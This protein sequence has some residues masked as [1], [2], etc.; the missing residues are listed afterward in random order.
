MKKIASFLIAT[1]MTVTCSFTAKAF[2]R[3]SNIP[4][5]LNAEQVNDSSNWLEIATDRD[6][7]GNNYSLIIRIKAIKKDVSFE[8]KESYRTG[9]FSYVHSN[10]RSLV[11]YWYS[12]LN[13]QILKDNAV[14]SDA[15]KKFGEFGTSTAPFG[16]SE[17]S[18]LQPKAGEQDVAFL[19]SYQ[20][21]YNFVSNRCW[22]RG[23]SEQPGDQVA[24]ETER[25]I[26][27]WKA[28]QKRGSWWLRTGSACE[29]VIDEMEEDCKNDPENQPQSKG[30]SV[31]DCRGLARSFEVT[32][33]AD[34]H[35]AMW[36]R[37]EVFN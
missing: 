19:L 6:D 12:R 27:N 21:A 3:V 5:I 34:I 7:Q 20:E 8:S 25:A 11:N 9:D 28:L 17:P 16:F 24:A 37:S 35:P 4:R 18:N 1:M 10:V 15:I 32:N 36:V 2:P 33:E 29:T 22:L 31:I 26:A 30:A 14:S 23:F 13:S